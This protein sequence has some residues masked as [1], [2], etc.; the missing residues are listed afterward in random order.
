[1]LKY[2]SSWLEE[3]EREVRSNSNTVELY[4]TQGRLEV[5]HKILSIQKELEEYEKKL[6]KEELKP[7]P[8]GGIK[9]AI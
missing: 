7:K 1:M 3:Q 5:L 4:R 2:F 6:K 8:L 9:L